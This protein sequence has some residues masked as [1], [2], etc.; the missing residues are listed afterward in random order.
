[1]GGKRRIDIESVG[2]PEILRQL[3]N[4]FDTEID[5]IRTLI[6]EVRIDFA[7][8][9]AGLIG[10]ALLSSAEVLMGTT[11]DLIANKHCIFM[12]NGTMHSLIENLVGTEPGNDVIPQN[13]YGAVALDV[14]A[15]K[16]LDATEA[17][18]NATGYD[19]AI[20]A[21]A[22]LPAVAADH[23]RLGYVTAMKSDGAFTFGTTLFDAANV[24]AAFTSATPSAVFYDL[25]MALTSTAPAVVEEV[26]SGT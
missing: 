10:D 16:T 2:S 17:A 22:G 15:D 14:G 26:E 8:A 3:L 1:M 11:K 9:K 19:T 6:N 21:A 7:T 18:D 5:A 13:K 12:I 24:T 4:A 23:V 25:G 20:L